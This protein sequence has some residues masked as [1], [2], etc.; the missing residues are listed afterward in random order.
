MKP[1]QSPLGSFL[2]GVA[3]VTAGYALA[4][5]VQAIAYPQFGIATTFSQDATIAAMFTLVSLMR[6]F[7]LRRTFEYFTGRKHIKEANEHART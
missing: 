7:L 4:L 6:S 1:G 5:L 2:E 3:N